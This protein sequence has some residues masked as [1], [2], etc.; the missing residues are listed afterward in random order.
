MT[1]P[2]ARPRLPSPP[3]RRAVVLLLAFAVVVS[4]ALA[5]ACS[6]DATSADAAPAGPPELPEAAGEPGDLQG[7]WWAF[8][9]DSP[10]RSLRMEFLPT[11]DPGAWSGSWISFSW[12]GSERADALASPSLPVA[13]AARIERG[14]LVITGPAPQLDEH[15]K[16]NGDSGRWELRLRLVSPP[17]KPPVYSG[18]MLHQ[19]YTGPRGVAVKLVRTFESWAN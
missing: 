12:R 4:G 9:R 17:G 6:P 10:Y 18:V 15:G 3:P 5:G 13:I 19:R 1:T 2:P 8:S 11:E 7:A 14:D 16:P